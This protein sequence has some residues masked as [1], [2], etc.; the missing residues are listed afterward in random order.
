MT[1]P[2]PQF[3][4]EVTDLHS[5]MAY[6]LNDK[7]PSHR[8]RIPKPL[9]LAIEDMGIRWKVF[10]ELL[11]QRRNEGKPFSEEDQQM[12]AYYDSLREAFDSELN[13]AAKLGKRTKKLKDLVGDGVQGV[14][15]PSIVT[16]SIGTAVGVILG[17]RRGS[18]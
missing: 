18:S 15:V 14:L 7:L 16:A 6:L 10:V 1:A 12:L 2:P 4:P 5:R 3:P 17:L 8:H 11:R 13:K 9:R